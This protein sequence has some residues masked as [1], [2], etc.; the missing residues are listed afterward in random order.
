MKKLVSRILLAALLS[1]TSAAALAE[2]A[3]VNAVG[4]KFD[5]VFVFIEAGDKVS[6]QNM[7]GHNVE[8]IDELVP[9]GTEKI[10]S[11]LGDDITVT[12]NEP[13]VFVYKCTPHWGARMGGVIVVGQPEDAREVAEAY[14][15]KVDSMKG[16]LLP[17]KGLLKKFIKELESRV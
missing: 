2:D 15:A 8:T 1:V 4:V 14:L 13:G 16:N 3:T 17:A 12:F 5:P 10:N 7:A 11:T 6:W 9:E